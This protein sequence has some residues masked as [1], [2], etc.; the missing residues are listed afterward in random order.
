MNADRFI[1]DLSVTQGGAI[2]LDQALDAGM[3]RDQVRY[4]LRSGRWSN[5]L[6]GS[7]LVTAMATIDDHL[8]AAIASLPGAVIAHESAAE[9]H[10]LSYVQ[11]G[12]ATVL[13][14]SQTTHEFPGVM[15][16]RCHD[17]NEDH[18]EVMDGL[19][20][21]TVAR[22]IVD[23]AA[24]LS[25]RNVAALLDDAVAA[26]TTSVADVAAVASAVGR[27][28]K[29]GTQAIR[30]L[31]EER[32]GPAKRG[33]RLE[34]KGN[35]LLQII[36]EHTAEIEYPIP[37][38][39]ENRYD[40]AYPSHRLAIEWDSRRWHTQAAAFQRDRIRDREAI[41]HGWRILRF[42]WED[43]VRRPGDVVSTVRRAL[44]EDG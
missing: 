10:R 35:A 3:S 37:W 29:P 21:T 9:R 22:T 41:L 31:L 44:A 2:R 1:H 7:Y 26:K 15:V 19:P 30:S 28:G 8:R 4:R 16:R 43:V 12:L 36:E 11:R 32:I 6:R 42:T 23:L 18:V 34:Q 27:A 40:A 17:L 13:V 33:T 24:I 20:V 25:E 5:L 14:H 38:R 39:P